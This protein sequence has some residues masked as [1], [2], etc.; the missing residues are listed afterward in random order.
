MTLRHVK[1]TRREL[2]LTPERLLR[3]RHVHETKCLRRCEGRGCPAPRNSARVTALR[4]LLRVLGLY[5][6]GRRNAET[7]LLRDIEFR[8]NHLPGAFDGFRILHITD[9]HFGAIA[10]FID[11]LQE[12]LAGIEVDLCVMT[13]DYRFNHYTPCWRVY[14]GLRAVMGAF[15]SREGT[16]AVLGNNDMSDFIGPMHSM[17]IRVLMNEAV[18]IERHGDSLWIAG[19]DDPHDFRADN[20][21]RACAGIPEGAFTL[22]LAHTPEIIARAQQFGIDLYLC[23]H[24]HGGQVCLPGIGPLFKNTRA[25]RRFVVGGPWTSGA[26]H[27]LTNRGLGAST[28]P[29][30]FACPPEA[31]IIELKRVPESILDMEEEQ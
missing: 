30:R 26:M 23:G 12:T 3:R 19:V 13:G 31:V 21:F 25:S 2:E 24:T 8:F 18:A 15:R 1:P 6:V 17:G 16:I 28:L 22:L 9:F 20:L 14:E 10:S 27:G 7:P 29:I 4:G 5:E 11:I